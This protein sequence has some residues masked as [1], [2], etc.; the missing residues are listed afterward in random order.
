MHAEQY[1]AFHYYDQALVYPTTAVPSTI[2]NCRDTILSVH[3]DYAPISNQEAISVSVVIR[4]TSIKLDRDLAYALL[5]LQFGAV[6][7]DIYY[8]DD[9]PYSLIGQEFRVSFQIE[10]LAQRVINRSL[11]LGR[12]PLVN[13]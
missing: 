6:D 11:A 5:K 3:V 7:Q 4:N 10:R 1:M 9:L 12:L 13:G 2:R 8:S